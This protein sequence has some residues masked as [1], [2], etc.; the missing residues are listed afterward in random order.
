L[1][2]EFSE[3]AGPL[4]AAN[5]ECG[6]ALVQLHQRFG[7]LEVELHRIPNW[8]KNSVIQNF[9][10][11]GKVNTELILGTLGSH[12]EQ[13]VYQNSKL[14]NVTDLLAKEAEEA[15]PQGALTLTRKAKEI[16]LDI[17]DLVHK[18]SDVPKRTK[19]A[20]EQYQTGVTDIRKKFDVIR[21]YLFDFSLAAYNAEHALNQSESDNYR[22]DAVKFIQSAIDLF[23]KPAT[24][25]TQSSTR[26]EKQTATSDLLDAFNGAKLWV[27]NPSVVKTPEKMAH[28]RRTS[29]LVGNSPKATPIEPLD[30][31][32]DGLTH[33]P[34]AS[35]E[36]VGFC[37]GAWGVAWANHPFSTEK[38]KRL[39]RSELKYFQ[40]KDSGGDKEALVNTLAGG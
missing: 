27:A 9:V 6:D 11:V 8:G 38:R 14:S 13:A 31:V 30:S 22:A 20:N 18:T 12:N 28:S 19:E 25:N 34:P 39:L 40:C 35:L 36:R 5:K 23:P 15:L 32:Y 26:I 33:C 24:G 16:L 17:F 7:D 21:G 10:A 37:Y 4:L 1:S 29:A 3:L 2:E